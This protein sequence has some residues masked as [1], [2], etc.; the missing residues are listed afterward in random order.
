MEKYFLYLH[1]F[2]GSPNSIK[3]NKLKDWL[4]IKHPQA[5]IEAPLLPMQAKDA[6]ALINGLIDQHQGK[7]IYIIGSSLGGFI[8]SL[9]KQTRNDIDKV[10]LINPAVRLDVI[11]NDQ[12]YAPFR[13]D[14]LTLYHMMPKVVTQQRD[15]LVLLQKDDLTTP[16]TYAQEAFPHA[17][18]DLKMG[19]GHHYD[20]I[21]ESF[22]LIEAF[23]QNKCL[24]N[25]A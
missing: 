4:A 7:S 10:I 1:G 14:A 8:A 11:A 21:D 18:I 5:I 24:V 17:H 13:D 22:A 3:A 6:L 12:T 9:L 15:Y 2:Q 25:Q 16:Y 23:I 20:D 19:Q